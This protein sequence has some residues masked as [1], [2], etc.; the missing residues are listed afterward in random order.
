[1]AELQQVTDLGV[2]DHVL[3]NAAGFCR[4]NQE[5]R[6]RQWVTCVTLAT[7]H[8]ETKHGHHELVCG[9]ACRFRDVRVERHLALRSTCTT[10]CH[11]SGEGCVGAGIRSRPTPIVLG[12]I[13]S[14]G[15]LSGY[16]V[17]TCA[18]SVT[19]AL[20]GNFEH[21]QLF[22]AKPHSLFPFKTCGRTPVVQLESQRPLLCA[23]TRRTMSRA[24]DTYNCKT[25]MRTTVTARLA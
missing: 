8:V 22:G 13:G 7:D 6:T 24:T 19:V 11:R 9:F 18:E 4:H 14:L 23:G 5:L 10:D 1:M 16:P 25:Q 15:T 3:H 17:V 21:Y 12:S 2:N 20:H